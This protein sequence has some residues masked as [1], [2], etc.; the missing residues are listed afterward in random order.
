MHHH[1]LSQADAD[2]A[3][4]VMS[5]LTFSSARLLKSLVDLFDLLIDHRHHQQFNIQPAAPEVVDITIL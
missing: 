1:R 3:A 4:Q 5:S 2:T